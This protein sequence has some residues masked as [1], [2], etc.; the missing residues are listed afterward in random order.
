MKKAKRILAGALAALIFAMSLPLSALADE[1]NVPA[2]SPSFEVSFDVDTG[3]KEI[4]EDP[5]ADIEATPEPTPEPTAEPTQEPTP[6]PES[7]ATPTPT[8]EPTAVPTATP[9]VTATP[10]AVPTSTPEPS[11]APSASPVV[12]PT[13]TP[14]PTPSP[15]PVVNPVKLE[16]DVLDNVDKDCIYL[17]PVPNSSEITQEYSAEHKAI[18]I[19]ASSGSPVYAAEDGTVSYVQIW[20]GSYDTTGMMSYGHMVEIRH[21]DGNT[22]LYAHLSL[23][24]I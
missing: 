17:F 14:T 18:D 23:I 20:D 5:P 15:Q 7:T 2:E 21:A 3:Q 11:A 6:T 24:H 13:S 8:A 4:S 22:T 9:G 10:T 12:T 1:A 16:H 19:A